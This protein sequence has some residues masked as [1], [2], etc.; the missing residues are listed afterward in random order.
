MIRARDS[1][2]QKLYNAERFLQDFGP[3]YE[4]VPE[5]QAYVDHLLSSAWFRRRWPR[6]AR[7]GIAVHDGRGRSRAVAETIWGVN[8]IKMPL[9]SRSKSII[10]HEIA[11]HCSDEAHGLRDVAAH[12][13]QFAGTLLELVTHEMGA[14]IGSELK[15][16]YKEGKVRYKAPR[17]RKPLTPQQRDVLVQRMATARLA[18]EAKSARL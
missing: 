10:I 4:T 17:Q 9:W 15:E 2:R 3:R 6:T 14:E 1:Q 11:H 5:I 13:W 8:V 18:K 7:K 16:S 12:G